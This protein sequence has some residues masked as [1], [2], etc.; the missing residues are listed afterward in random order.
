MRSTAR[1][2]D[3]ELYDARVKRALLVLAAC[4]SAPAAP[5]KWPVPPRWRTEVIP[6]PLDFAPSLAHKGV[7]EIR[8]PPGFFDP[9]SPDRW[10]YAFVWRLDDAADLAPAVLGA[11]LKTYFE[12]LTKAVDPEG[13]APVTVDVGADYAIRAHLAD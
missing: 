6:F 13:K 7:E 5:T 10:S 8:F 11:E 4:S 12:G 2:I 3:D 1:S 9:A